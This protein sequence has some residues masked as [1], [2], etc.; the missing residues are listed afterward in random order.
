MIWFWGKYLAICK[1]P[2]EMHLPTEASA[3]RKNSL[4]YCKK[5]LN[6]IYN[7]LYMKMSGFKKPK[8]SK[9]LWLIL[10]TINIY[11]IL[12]YNIFISVMVAK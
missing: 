11:Y 4:S 10:S 8:P 7:K 12:M 3:Q 2:T 5:Q 9:T 6:Y 1:N